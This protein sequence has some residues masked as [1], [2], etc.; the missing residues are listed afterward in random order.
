MWRRNRWRNSVACIAVASVVVLAAP[1]LA[2]AQPAAKMHRIGWLGSG[3]PPPDADRSAGQFQ[4][5]LRDLGYV[6]GRNLSIEYRYGD[7]AAER[8]PALAATLARLPVD[9]IVTSGESAALAAK[10][11]TKSIPIVATEIG[12]DPVEA[13][14]VASLGRPEGNVTGLASQSEELWDKRLALLKELVPKLLR[15]VVFWNPTNPGNSSCVGA[16]KV[17]AQVMGIQPRFLEVRDAAGLDRAF[18]DFAKD[19]PDAL[20]TCWDTVSMA[21]ARSI[22][23]F[24]LNLRVATLAPLR[25]YVV[26]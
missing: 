9:V 13:G 16:I 22:A 21:N 26:A 20:V 12:W 19:R 6:E 17:A 11:A 14:L 2:I 15:V 5:A 23:D 24:A 4:Q 7:G 3:S 18:G 10:G 25:E 1:A 8:L